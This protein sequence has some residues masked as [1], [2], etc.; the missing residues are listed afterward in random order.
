MAV[1]VTDW[2]VAVGTFDFIDAMVDDETYIKL[3]DEL[4]TPPPE[5]GGRPSDFPRWLAFFYVGLIT[6]YRSQRRVETELAHPAVWNYIC[7]RVR[8]RYPDRPDLWPQHDKTPRRHHFTYIRETHLKDD[9][10]WERVSARFRILAAEQAVSIGLCRRDGTGSL[11]HP[12]LTRCPFADGKVVTPVYKAKRGTYVKRNGRRRLVKADPTAGLHT[13]GGGAEAFGNKF[14]LLGVRHPEANVRMILDFEWVP[15]RGGEA[16]I[17]VDTMERTFPLLPG[18]LG[19]LYDTALRGV[20]C[21]RLLTRTGVLPIVPVTAASGGKGRGAKRVEREVFI[22]RRT[23]A[24]GRKIAL[25]TRG[26]ALGYVEL[27]DGGDGVFVGLD[28]AKIQRE[29]NRDGTFRWYGEYRLP[30][31]LGG[32]SI[33]VRLN[34]TPEDRLKGLNRAEHLRAIAPGSADYE[35]LHPHRNNIE[36]INRYL[37]DTMWLS[38]AHSVG[39]I[40]QRIDILGFALVMN[41][42]AV[43]LARAPGRLLA[44]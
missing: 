29:R 42:M 15:R 13:V 2:R 34:S 24:S 44:A 32:G 3:G 16:K 38:R 25:Y 11:T 19:P 10:I 23:L 28:L 17:A 5:N 22:E 9:A 14:V 37:D 27:D 39:G 8:E 30:E 41:S 40:R 21:D 20:H 12:D 35:R 26:G 36:S 7:G 6:V 1:T 43:A 4:P 33:R 31:E 18:I